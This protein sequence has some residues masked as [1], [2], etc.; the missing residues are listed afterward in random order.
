MKTKK[1]ESGK[2]EMDVLEGPGGSIEV[3][4]GEGMNE[5]SSRGLLWED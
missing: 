5:G 4:V 2:V 3:C 1:V